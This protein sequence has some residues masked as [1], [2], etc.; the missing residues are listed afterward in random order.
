MTSSSTQSSPLLVFSTK[1]PENI[2]WAPEG[3]ESY[4]TTWE[5]PKQSFQDVSRSTRPSNRHEQ[6]KDG[7]MLPMDVQEATLSQL[8]QQSLKVKELRYVKTTSIKEAIKQ[9]IEETLAEKFK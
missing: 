8:D 3:L 1:N 6:P 4:V 7:D 9:I 5:C 2:D